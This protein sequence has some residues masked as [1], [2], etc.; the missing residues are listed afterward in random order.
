[1]VLATRRLD[2]A[3]GGCRYIDEHGQQVWVNKSGRWA[4]LLI[5]CGPNL[6]PQP[7]ALFSRSAFDAVGGLD[8]RFGWAFDQDLFTKFVRSYRT[9]HVRSIVSSFRWHGGSLSAGSRTGSVRESSLIRVENLPPVL[10]P[11]SPLWEVPV[12]QAIKF[13]GRRMNRRTGV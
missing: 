12:R 6:I 11:L 3:W 7:G 8:T 1:M 10:R 2:F 13:A 5:R 9:G 4:A